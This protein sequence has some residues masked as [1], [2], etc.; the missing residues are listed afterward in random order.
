MP[1]VGFGDGCGVLVQCLGA[2]EVY[3]LENACVQIYV[4][5]LRGY[6]DVTYAEERGYGKVVGLAVY[7]GK[8]AN[9]I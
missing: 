4:R 1:I 9:I 8:G 3:G 7:F 2:R 5:A 6:G